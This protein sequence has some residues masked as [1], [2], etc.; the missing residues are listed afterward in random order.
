MQASIGRA[1]AVGAVLIAVTGFSGSAHAQGTA[2]PPPVEGPAA[3]TPGGGPPP[4]PAAATPGEFATRFRWG[5]WGVGGPY[6][7][8]GTSGG[9]GGVTARFGAQLTDM[10]AVYGQP[11]A[12]IGGGASVGT[13]SNG[14]SE[15]ASALVVGG[16]GAMG[17]ATFGDIFFVAL[18]PEFLD[19]TAGSASQTVGPNGAT[20]SAAAATG[21]FFSVAA[22]AGLA[23]GSVGP[24]RR[25][26]FTFGL[27]FHSIF[28]PGGVV[29]VPL[30]GLGY[31]AF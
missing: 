29:V 6:F 14:I 19:G 8:S 15:S 18:G 10:F 2:P 16:V 12:L 26:A 22:R 31:D 11:V 28:T 4:P 7:F 9:V 23:L 13:S 27:D 1:S 25:K 5:I 17:E 3:A 21:A 20:Q 24:E 30:V